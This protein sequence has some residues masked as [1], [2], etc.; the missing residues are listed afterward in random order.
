MPSRLSLALAL[1]L[2]LHGGLLVPDLWKRPPV[3]QRQ[4]AVQATL[5]PAQTPEMPP[6][7]TLLKNTLDAERQAPSSTPPTPARHEDKAR[8]AEK[9]TIGAARK[10]LAQHLYYPPAAVAQGI[11]GEVRLL[12]AVDADGV[13]TDVQVA[14]SSGHP[15]LD[16]A[17]QKAAWAMG[18]VAGT[19]PRQL[20][21][22]V[23]FRLQ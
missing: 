17:A 1:S 19:P 18:R 14:A 2:A 20:L 21:L 11:E 7:E 10:K 9:R 8:A 6:A 5:R 4:P 12:V 3:A 23:V 16:N 15:L 13:V 22:P